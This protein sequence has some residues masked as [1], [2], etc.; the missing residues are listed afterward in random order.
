MPRRGSAVG[1]AVRWWCCSGTVRGIG[2]AGSGCCRSPAGTCTGSASPGTPGGTP[3]LRGPD[4]GRPARDRGRCPGGGVRQRRE[5][6][7]YTVLRWSATG[8]RS[9]GVARGTAEVPG[10]ATASERFGT[11]IALHDLD[12]D[13]RAD[14]VVS[15]PGSRLD[16]EVTG[17]V[18][19][20]PSTASGRPAASSSSLASAVELRN[21]RGLGVALGWSPFVRRGPHLQR[22]GVYSAISPKTRPPAV[23][24]PPGRVGPNQATVRMPRGSRSCGEP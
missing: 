4:R 10:A 8:V 24:R 23:D 21:L 5:V 20:L 9:V 22:R 3:S 2:G 19:L 15:A 7:G 11:A 14:V 18:G 17:W 16:G 6:G 1:T 13:Q 12:E